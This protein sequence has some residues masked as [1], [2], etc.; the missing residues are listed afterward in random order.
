MV[1]VD[2]V[3]VVVV[4]VVS[5]VVVAAVVVVVVVV[6]VAVVVVVVLAGVGLQ[7]TVLDIKIN[8]DKDCNRQIILFLWLQIELFL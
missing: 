6:V 8:R 5:V 7:A 2:V 1:V 3:P 4:F